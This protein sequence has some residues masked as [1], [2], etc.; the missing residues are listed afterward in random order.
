L[1]VTL[2][3]GV[4]AV[5]SDPRLSSGPASPNVKLIGASCH[6]V[7]MIA[8]TARLR[9]GGMDAGAFAEDSQQR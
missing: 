1:N 6:V 5:R 7:I 8:P 4:P 3:D 9:K 2:L